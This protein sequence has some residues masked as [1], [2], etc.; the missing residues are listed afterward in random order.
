MYST[1]TAATQLATMF[2]D[3]GTLIGI[4]IA[5]V[6]TGAIALVGLGFGWRHLTKRVTG[7]KF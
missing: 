6:L 7:K 2:T 4:V 3:T 5:A 1:S